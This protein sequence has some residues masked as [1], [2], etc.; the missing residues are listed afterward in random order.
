MATFLKQWLERAQYDF[1]TAQGMLRIRKYLY[2]GFMCQQAIEKLLKAILASQS[3]EIPYIHNLVRLAELSQVYM[4]RTNDQQLHLQ[5]LTPFCIKARY[6]DYK[7]SLSKMLTRIKAQE[8]LTKTERLY[9]CLQ[10]HIQ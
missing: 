3:Q 7:D 6:G 5:N 9:Q 8:L 10:K 1:E 2:V 4:K